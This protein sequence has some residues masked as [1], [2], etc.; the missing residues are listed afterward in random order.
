MAEIV[1]T[2]SAALQ[3]ADERELMRQGYRFLDEKRVLLAAE[4]LRLLREHERMHAALVERLHEARGALRE[5]LLRHGLDGLQAYP[6]V[7]VEPEPKSITEIVVGS[8]DFDTL[9][10]QRQ[11]DS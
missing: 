7:P 11:D 2:R 5:A 10:R 8:E 4:M 6:P 3:L 1:P 9:T